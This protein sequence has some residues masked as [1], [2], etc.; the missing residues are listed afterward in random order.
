[1]GEQITEIRFRKLTRNLKG[2]A[3]AT[4]QPSTP[5]GSSRHRDQPPVRHRAA[6]PLQ[7]AADPPPVPVPAPVPVGGS[8][9]VTNPFAAMGGA[10]GRERDATMCAAAPPAACAAP[11]DT[12]EKASSSVLDPFAGG[13]KKKKKGVSDPFGRM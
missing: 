11:A 12:A 3:A 13:A 4:S 1:M 5:T 10:G 2:V 9:S 8:S 6:P 7:P